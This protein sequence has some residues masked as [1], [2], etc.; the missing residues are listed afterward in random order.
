MDK[1]Q[2]GTTPGEKK[3]DVQDVANF[4]SMEELTKAYQAGNPFAMSY[5]TGLYMSQYAQMAALS[6]YG[7]PANYYSQILASMGSAAGENNVNHCN[8]ATAKKKKRRKK[9]KG[10]ETVGKPN[11]EKILPVHNSNVLSNHLETTPKNSDTC[12]SEIK[13]NTLKDLLEKGTTPEDNLS[14]KAMPPGELT[15]TTGSSVVQ[16]PNSHSSAQKTADNLMKELL[17]PRYV[18]T[19]ST[20]ALSPTATTTRLQTQHVSPN[21]AFSPRNLKKS[22]VVSPRNVN[23]LPLTIGG[24]GSPT[25][26]TGVH[27][28]KRLRDVDRTLP[29]NVVW[30]DRWCHSCI[31]KS[32][33]CEDGNENCEERHRK[34][35]TV[36]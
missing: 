25:H 35:N 34:L 36:S 3:D 4:S 31:M 22:P 12:T 9:P 33:P 28:D 1:G 17:S 7:L 8:Q 32:G 19:G 29:Q 21:P 26:V 20:K 23:V 11:E 18:E 30:R 15:V 14:V 24:A 27:L 13:C 5:L 2:G 10:T 16:V 6:G